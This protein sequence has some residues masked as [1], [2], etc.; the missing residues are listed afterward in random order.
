MKRKGIQVVDKDSKYG[1]K[2]PYKLKALDETVDKYLTKDRFMKVLNKGDSFLNKA[3]RKFS[4]TEEDFI[5]AYLG[6]DYNRV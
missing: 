3:G 6:K 5:E 2:D 1:S 4:Y